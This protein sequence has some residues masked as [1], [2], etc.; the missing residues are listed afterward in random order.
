MSS[1][2]GSTT[3]RRGLRARSLLDRAGRRWRAAGK[4]SRERGE[5]RGCEA[6]ESGGR[7]SAA[8]PFLLDQPLVPV[9]HHDQG[10]GA[11]DVH[12]APTCS[13]AGRSRRARFLSSNLTLGEST[14]TSILRGFAMRALRSASHALRDMPLGVWKSGGVVGE[15][16]RDVVRRPCPAHAF[17]ERSTSSAL[18]AAAAGGGGGAALPAARLRLW[19]RRGGGARR[20][21]GGAGFGGG[22]LAAAPAPGRRLGGG[23]RYRLRRRAPASARLSR[24]RPC[25]GARLAV[26]VLVCEKRSLM[27][28][29]CL[30]RPGCCGRAAAPCRRPGSPSSR[31]CRRGF[32]GRSRSSDACG[33][34]S[35]ASCAPCRTA[36]CDA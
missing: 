26:A 33:S 21:C 13:A 8:H 18:P 24:P 22:R 32:R 35:R 14:S 25:V 4:A 1:A 6:D 29:A 7:R 28:S 9:L 31:R 34:P 11:G 19:A 10:L 15:V 17:T 23:R 30:A 36:P 3:L 16:A 2:S 27:S 20:L 5:R 12:A